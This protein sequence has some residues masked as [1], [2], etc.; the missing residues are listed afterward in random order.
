[1]RKTKTEKLD[2]LFCRVL[3]ANIS[4]NVAIIHKRLHG[5]KNNNKR[6]DLLLFSNFNIVL[7]KYRHPKR[8]PSQTVRSFIA[9]VLFSFIESIY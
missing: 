1:M 2:F 4:Y 8:W 9:K 7:S 5:L 3:D 6:N